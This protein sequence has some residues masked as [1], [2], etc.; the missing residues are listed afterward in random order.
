MKAARFGFTVVAAPVPA[1][2]PG[3]DGYGDLFT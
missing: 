2:H 3:A 1:A